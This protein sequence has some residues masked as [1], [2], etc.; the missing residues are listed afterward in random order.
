[1]QVPVLDE[2][3]GGAAAPG[4]RAPPPT[5]AQPLL[6]LLAAFRA[7]LSPCTMFRVLPVSCHD[8]PLSALWVSIFL[9]TL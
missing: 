4:E 7:C 8:R 9:L 6:L 1:M 2:A 3:G 5:P